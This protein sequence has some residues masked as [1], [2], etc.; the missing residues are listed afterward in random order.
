MPLRRIRIFAMDVDGTLT[1]G[2]IHLDDTGV[3][4]KSFSVR[5]GF[6]IKHLHLAGLKTAFI[7]GRNSPLVTNRAR[8][9]GVTEVFQGL[10]NKVDA[11]QQIC[12]RHDLALFEV[13]YIG[14]DLNDLP[15]MRQ[16]GYAF[17]VADARDEVKE[18][19]HFV[20]S[21]PGGG[22]AVSEAAE[23]LLR[24][25]GKWDQVLARYL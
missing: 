21:A 6:A 7:S 18:F 20:T 23:K 10:E 11:I 14:D 5:D 17:A 22:G 25:Q 13:G 15:V 24:A 9:L 16:V 12:E 1:D 4:T 19:A 3:E 8:E 2:R